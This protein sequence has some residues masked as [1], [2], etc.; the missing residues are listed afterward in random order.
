MNE[1]E[2][3]EQ[4]KGPDSISFLL[5][6][7]LTLDQI[8]DNLSCGI[9]L[10]EMVQAI[11]NRLARG[12]TIDD[13]GL[14]PSGSLLD[15]L[16][17]IKPDE[18]YSWND[19]GA[20]KL[21]ADIFRKE[22]RFCTTA[23]EWM[24]YNGKFWELDMGGMRVAQRA[25]ALADALLFYCTTINDERQKQQY[26]K[27]VTQFGR[28][29]NRETMVKDA[30]SE[31]FV[32]QKDFDADG[33]LFNCLNGVFNLRTYEL[34]PHKPEYLLTKISNVVYDPEARS[35]RFER[36]ISEIM[37]ADEAKIKYLQKTLGL[38][39]TTDT[40]LE[41]CWIW[42]GATTR[43]GKS[44]LA[45]TILYMMGADKGYSLSMPPETLAQRKNKDTR[46]ASGDIARLD[47]CRFLNASEPPKRML[48]DS[49][50]LKTLLGRDTI[51]ARHLH[52]REFQFIPVFKL[53]VNTNYLPLIPDDTLF[54]SGR[55]NV[56]TFDRHFEP[57]EQDHRLKDTLKTPENIS[58]AF[59]WCVEGL[60]RYRQ[61]GLTPPDSVTCATS[62]YRR[63]SDKIQNFIDECLIE[64]DGKNSDGKKVY[65]A[66]ANWCEANGYGT[67]SKRNFFDEMRNKGLYADRG[68]VGGCRLRNVIL[69]HEIADDEPPPW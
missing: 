56:L 14:D 27:Y 6:N 11:K 58:G 18:T 15:C 57:H 19:A 52:E 45:E 35:E 54:T 5:E 31:Y 4:N 47:G 46:Q 40:S 66:F 9:S 13:E 44:V 55:I 64:A 48:I 50:L 43:N 3:N 32:S 53:F 59:N 63:N 38:A 33:D 67:D 7:G 8:S 29:C 65:Q 39:L 62:D 2:K 21:F 36:F 41:T 49:A 10:D 25:K 28:L 68:W 12:E 42:Y 24:F 17:V 26:T 22:C 61:E 20:G 51:T 37:Q 16:R 1:N 34:L 60:K 23:K 30:R 69:N